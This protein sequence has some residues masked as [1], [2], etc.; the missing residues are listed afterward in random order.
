MSRICCMRIQ[1]AITFWQ[2]DVWCLYLILRL[3]SLCNL[4]SHLSVPIKITLF[5]DIISKPRARVKVDNMS[6]HTYHH[7]TGNIH[8]KYLSFR[9]STDYIYN[10]C[11]GNIHLKNLRQTS[12]C[13]GALFSPNIRHFDAKFIPINRYAQSACL[14]VKTWSSVH[15]L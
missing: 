8:I 4:T 9:Q 10:H 6:R 7:C 13:L 1:P 14:S 11:T 2:I 5:L 3:C 15:E 12:L